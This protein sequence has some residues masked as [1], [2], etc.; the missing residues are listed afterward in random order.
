MF[1]ARLSTPSMQASR[2][3]AS[4]ARTSRAATANG[5]AATWHHQADKGLTCRPSFS[6]RRVRVTTASRAADPPSWSSNA[7]ALPGAS[8]AYVP[9]TH[10]WS[11]APPG[12]ALLMQLSA[13]SV[14]RAIERRGADSHANPFL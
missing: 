8:D 4:L 3:A 13:A 10:S 1:A 14:R 12:E 7:S 2:A 11:L 9:I 5:V 6:S